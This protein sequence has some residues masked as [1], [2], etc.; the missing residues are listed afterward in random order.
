MDL[1]NTV[2]KNRAMTELMHIKSKK[3]PGFG[4]TALFR[5]VMI[6]LEGHQF[7]LGVRRFAIDLFERGVMRAIVLDE[8]SGSEDS[9]SESERGKQNRNGNGYGNGHVR[10]NEKNDVQ[11]GSESGSESEGPSEGHTERGRSGSDA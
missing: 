2:L 11:S 1:G 3:A 9:G 8:E 6:L 10:P 4:E 5:K 7:R